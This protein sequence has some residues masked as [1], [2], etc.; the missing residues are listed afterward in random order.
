MISEFMRL[1][2][3]LGYRLTYPEVKDIMET[4]F[5]ILFSDG[6]MTENKIKHAIQVYF[7]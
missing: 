3:I 2:R 7:H 5:D 4:K 1:G 6:V